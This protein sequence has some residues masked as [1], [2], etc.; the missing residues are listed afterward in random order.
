[1]TLRWCNLITIGKDIEHGS[2]W[3]ANLIRRKVGSGETVRYWEENWLG[4]FNLCCE[5]EDLHGID[6]DCNIGRKDFTG[7]GSG[8]RSCYREWLA[9][10]ELQMSRFGAHQF[11][12]KF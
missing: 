11:R 2:N 9:M 6:V 5:I 10:K 8:F 12:H 1:M 3:F 4:N 7:I